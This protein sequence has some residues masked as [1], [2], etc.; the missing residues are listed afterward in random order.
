M[1]VSDGCWLTRGGK[2]KNVTSCDNV[3]LTNILLA[4]GKRPTQRRTEGSKNKQKKDLNIKK[5][6][7][8]YS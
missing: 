6:L 2:T 3:F 7:T 5:A 4:R 8:D 1:R